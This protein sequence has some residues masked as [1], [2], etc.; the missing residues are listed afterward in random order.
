MRNVFW[1]TIWY[2]YHDAGALRVIF[3]VKSETGERFLDNTHI[4][5][6]LVPSNRV[7]HNQNHKYADLIGSNGRLCSL[8]RG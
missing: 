6:I 3:Q 7:D 2:K 4:S 1:V 8:E 5:G